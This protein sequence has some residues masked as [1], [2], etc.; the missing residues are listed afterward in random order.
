[1]A[2]AARA[3]AMRG[4][5]YHPRH[6]YLFHYEANE[7]EIRQRLWS[8]ACEIEWEMMQHF[9]RAK[10]SSRD[11][12]IGPKK[13]ELERWK[14]QY[15]A[16]GM[17]DGELDRLARNVAFISE[18]MEAKVDFIAVDNPHATR[19]TLHILA[20]VA[21][22]EARDISARTVAA[23]ARSRK[24]LGGK[25]WDIPAAVAAELDGLINQQTVA[26]HRYGEVMRPTID[27]EDFA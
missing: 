11:G 24:T 27:T 17:I 9:D 15:Q 2:E 1:M 20:A 6:S 22:Q 7:H 8:H 16:T 14:D 25:R 23:L 13:Y 3:A 26:G 4:E 18:L 12:P 10:M 21:E 5:V 19:L